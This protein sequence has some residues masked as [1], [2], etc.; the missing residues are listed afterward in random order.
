MDQYTLTIQL[1]PLTAAERLQ[2][3]S[4][5][6]QLRGVQAIETHVIYSRRDDLKSVEAGYWS[7]LLEMICNDK[8]IPPCN[9]AKIALGVPVAFQDGVLIVQH[10]DAL[11]ANQR[12]ARTFSNWIVALHPGARV[13]FEM[14]AR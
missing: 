13:Q 3:V 11:W 1:D 2:L 12:F 5:I 6:S 4:A 14:E 10:P 8:G 7:T 9:K